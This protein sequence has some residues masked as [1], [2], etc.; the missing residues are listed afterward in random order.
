MK[1]YIFYITGFLCVFILASCA[2]SKKYSQIVNSYK[3]HSVDELV[4]NWGPPT[5]IYKMRNGMKMYIYVRKNGTFIASD[6]MN[7]GMSYIGAVPVKCTTRFIVNPKTGT[8]LT[9][10]WK[11]NGCKAK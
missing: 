4:M 10:S 6:N 9:W 5:H 1:K 11:G 8:I 2:T 7:N 3:D